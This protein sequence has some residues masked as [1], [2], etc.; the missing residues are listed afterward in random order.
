[1]AQSKYEAL[2][3]PQ[4]RF[5][6]LTKFPNTNGVTKR[7]QETWKGL[8]GGEMFD[9]CRLAALLIFPLLALGGVLTGLVFLN[10]M[11]RGHSTYSSSDQGAISLGSALYL[12]FSSA[13]RLAFVVSISSR[14]SGQL[15]PVA[16]VLVSYRLAHTLTRSSDRCSHSKLP[17]PFQLEM[18]I[19][20]VDGR[21]TALWSYILYVLGARHKK[22]LTI[23]LLQNAVVMLVSLVVLR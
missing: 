10:R 3:G 4:N 9:I 13:S 18:I 15:V 20:L 11:P 23:P 16:M 14:V 6:T 22:V 7:E 5:A 21:L 2:R 19:R 8:M 12:E 1:M 17:S